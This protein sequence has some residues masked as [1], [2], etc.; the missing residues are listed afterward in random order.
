L[1]FQKATGT[2]GA[3]RRGLTRQATPADNGFR[4]VWRLA[5]R[6]PCQAI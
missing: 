2:C 1:Q 3:W 5:A 4:G 6:V